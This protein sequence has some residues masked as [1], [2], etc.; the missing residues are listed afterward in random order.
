LPRILKESPMRSL[1]LLAALG[2]VAC[3]LHAA[4][5]PLT[6]EQFDALSVGRTFFYNS[7]GQSYGAEQY[8]PGRK[9]IWAFTGDDCRKGEWYAEGQF[10]CFVYD[11]EPDPQCWTFHNGMDGLTA[12]F[13]GETD[14]QPLV[15]IE[16]SPEPMKC[17]GP[18]VGV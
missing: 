17:M 6:P 1:S 16:Q 18:N 14:N 10:I 5:A 4:D 8:L 9:V 11:D 13:R 7:G 3:P 2:L 12:V 15:A